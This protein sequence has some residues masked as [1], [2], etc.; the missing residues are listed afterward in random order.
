MV[1]GY[2]PERMDIVWVDLDPIRGHEQ[3]GVRPVLV[4][5]PRKYNELVGLML[6][7]PITSHEKG[8]AFEVHIHEKKI[9]GVILADQIRSLDWKKRNARFVQKAPRVIFEGVEEKIRALIFE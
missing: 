3:A 4:L 5:S 7:C 9:L 6:V 1:K 2:V 8:Y